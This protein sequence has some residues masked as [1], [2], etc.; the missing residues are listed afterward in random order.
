MPAGSQTAVPIMA[1]GA[2]QCI[3][4]VLNIRTGDCISH[5]SP[6]YNQQVFQTLLR[7]IRSHWRGW[8]IVL[9]A[10]KHSAQRAKPSRAL[11]RQLG[12]ELRW[13]PTACPHLNPVDHLWRHLKNDVL[14]NL[15][16]PTLPD[17]L[18]LALDH[19]TRLSPR[20][21]LRKAGVL[22]EDFWLRDLVS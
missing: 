4:T 5:P 18:Q 3:T 16:T 20:A 15:P 17:M 7:Q 9:F 13:L 12:I 10:D 19:I 1:A 21:R 22:A 8:R 2:S 11:A 6:T 14:A